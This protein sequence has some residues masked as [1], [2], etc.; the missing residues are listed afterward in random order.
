MKEAPYARSYRTGLRR[1]GEGGTLDLEYLRYFTT[2]ATLKNVSLAAKKLQYAQSNLSTRMKQLEEQLGVKLFLRQAHGVVLTEQGEVFLHYAQKILQELDEAKSAVRLGRV[3]KGTLA[4]GA[5]ESAAVSFVPQLLAPFHASHPEIA[6]KVQTAVSKTCLTKVMQGELDCAFVA[7]PTTA[8]ELAS[9]TIR[10]EKL[11]LLYSKGDPQASYAELLQRP[12]L[13]LPQGCTYR[14][15]LERWLA[16]LGIFSTSYIEFVS[17]GAIL[18]SICAGL[19]TA[20]F[21]LG[22]IQLFADHELLDYV[23]IPEPYGSVA[24]QFV[25]RRTE[26]MDKGLQSFIELLQQGDHDDA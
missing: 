25:W 7:G 23:E 6:L 13:V 22:A 14:S 10:T 24:I 5:M 21:P 20:L 9:L 16:D 12:L 2:V 18:A 8:P 4:I 15:I 26:F 11:V 1:P 17:L 3:C 19:G